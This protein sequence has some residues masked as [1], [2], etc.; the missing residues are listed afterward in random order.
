MNPRRMSA[1]VTFGDNVRAAMAR[2]AIT[3]QAEL[4]RRMKASQGQ[5]SGWL[6]A[7]NI[8]LKNVLRFAKAL[9]CPVESL[10]DG[11]DPEYARQR[12]ATDYL[13]QLREL[14]PRLSQDEQRELVN[15]ARLLLRLQPLPPDGGPVTAR[16]PHAPEEAP[17]L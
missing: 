4:A 5:V 17:I 9:D 10:I 2:A 12:T 14:A 8:E 1:I 3:T 11:I 16:Q 7:D 15:L 13:T 6:D